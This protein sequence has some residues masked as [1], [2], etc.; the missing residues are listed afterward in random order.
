MAVL[1]QQTAT[2]NRLL[3]QELR[4]L[5]VRKRVDSVVYLECVACAHPGLLLVFCADDNSRTCMD[6]EGYE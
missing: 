4:D 5:S 2:G 1:R 6:T 3:E